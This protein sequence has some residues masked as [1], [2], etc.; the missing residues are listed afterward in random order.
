MKTNTPNQTDALAALCR[1]IENFNVRLTRTVP[2]GEK[3]TIGLI[4]GFTEIILR[5]VWPNLCKDCQEHLSEYG[6]TKIE[7]L[8]AFMEKYNN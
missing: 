5:D 7:D 6:I 8:T 2:D 3:I 4:C 1:A